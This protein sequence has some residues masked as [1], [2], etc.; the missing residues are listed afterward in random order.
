[1]RERRGRIIA[2][3]TTV[4]RALESAD[5][6][7]H[8]RAGGGMATLRVGPATA[9]RVIDAVLTGVHE[10]GTSHHDLLRAFVDD[11]TLGAWTPN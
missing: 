6:G 9:L 10:P 2:I 1:M 11:A 3:G 4:V 5:L 7:G 8:V